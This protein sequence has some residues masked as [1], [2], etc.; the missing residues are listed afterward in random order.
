MVGEESK[1]NEAIFR[2]LSLNVT[3]LNRLV[4]LTCSTSARK[5]LINRSKWK[6]VTRV[7]IS[8]RKGGQGHPPQATSQSHPLPPPTHTHTNNSN[9]SIINTRFWAAAPKG[10]MTYA[11]TYVEISPP[12]SSSPSL[13]PPPLEVQ[14]LAL[15]LKLKPQGSNPSLKAQIPALKLKSQPKK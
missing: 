12:P 10:P 9:C 6:Q 3:N 1:G 11:L 7:T 14:I 13:Y 5:E 4:D 8:L 2:T 15:R